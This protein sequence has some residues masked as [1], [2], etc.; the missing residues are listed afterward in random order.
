MHCSWIKYVSICSS[1]QSNLLSSRSWKWIYSWWRHKDQDTPKPA[2]PSYRSAS[3]CLLSS[4]PGLGRL[5]A[6]HGPLLSCSFQCN[7]LGSCP[8]ESTWFGELRHNWGCRKLWLT[9]FLVTPQTAYYE[10]YSFNSFAVSIWGIRDSL[11][12]SFLLCP[13]KWPWFFQDWQTLTDY[14]K[15]FASLPKPQDCSLLCFNPLIFSL[16]IS[17]AHWTVGV[18][19]LQWREKGL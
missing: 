12:L 17:I 10:I 15:D 11:S 4:F 6:M 19:R 8:E 5:C 1:V 3:D 14:G 16:V 9:W 7:F 18:K 2:A 13:Q